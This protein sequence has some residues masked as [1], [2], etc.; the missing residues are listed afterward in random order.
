E[1]TTLKCDVCVAGTANGL[2]KVMTG[3]DGAAFINGGAGADTMT[4]GVGNDT[5]YVDNAGDVVSENVGE[6]TDTIISTI[7]LALGANLEDLT[8]S[9]TAAN[10]TGN[11]L[12]NIIRGTNG[13]NVIDGGDGNDTLLG[14]GGHDTLTGGIGNDK[15]NGGTGNDSM[16]GGTGDDNYYVDSAGDVVTENPGEGTADK[17]ITTIDYTLGANVERLMLYGSAAINGT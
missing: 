3:N 10:G 7:S 17:V 13:V 12:A 5:Y 11:A 9:G 1:T 4:G 8:L 16:S 2:A 6:G 14:N 15:L